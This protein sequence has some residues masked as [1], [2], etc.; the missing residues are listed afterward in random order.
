MPFVSVIIPCYKQAD[1]LPESVESVVSQTYESWECIIVNDGSPDNTKKIAQ[2]LINNHFQKNILL[3]N[4]KNGGPA[5]AR[6]CGVRKSRGDYILFL[7]ADDKIAPEFLKETVE[8]L[9][10]QKKIGFVYTT[11]EMFGET[12]GFC[13]RGEFWLEKFLRKNQATVSALFRRELFEAVGGMKE[14]LGAGFEDWDFWISAIEK[15]WKGYFLSKPYFYYRIRHGSK[16]EQI[17]KDK[18]KYDFCRA[19]I[20]VKHPKLYTKQEQEWADFLI[21][22]KL[23]LNKKNRVRAD[24]LKAKAV[25][26]LTEFYSPEELTE[27]KRFLKLIEKGFDLK[28]I[29]EQVNFAADFKLAVL[30]G[31]LKKA[32]FIYK[33]GMEDDFI[34]LEILYNFARLYR[35]TGDFTN[36]QKLYIDIIRSKNNGNQALPALSFF[37]LGEMDIIKENTKSAIINFEKC[38]E[39]MP[40]HKKARERIV[41]LQSKTKVSLDVDE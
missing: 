29:E 20:I 17:C 24:I 19:E 39:I 27:G 3:L 18:I 15:G 5:A 31:D 6:N 28:E 8:I 38:L 23:P 1:F 7:D 21:N 14:E 32:E 25:S 16:H 9:V 34:P 10:S 11:V 12:T 30:N 41:A 13:E 22:Q 37:H 2:Q 36:A 40:E 35:L 33:T 4:R 26:K